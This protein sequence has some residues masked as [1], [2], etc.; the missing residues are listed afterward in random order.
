M[1]V[2]KNNLLYKE[3]KL[4]TYGRSHK[5]VSSNDYDT[6]LGRFRLNDYLLYVY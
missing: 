5:N 2:K 4:K 1:Y 6:L 3:K